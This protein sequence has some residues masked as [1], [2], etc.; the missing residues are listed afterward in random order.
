MMLLLPLLR[1]TLLLV[2]SP[3]G[4]MGG[5]GGGGMSGGIVRSATDMRLEDGCV[6]LAKCVTAGCVYARVCEHV[7]LLC[8]RTCTCWMYLLR[9]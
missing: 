3:A 2:P 1:H 9:G 4:A 8:V 6:C 7:R 5:M